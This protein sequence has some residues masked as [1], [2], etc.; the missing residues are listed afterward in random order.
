MTLRLRLPEWTTGTASVSVNGTT[1]PYTT[2]NGYAVLN[3]TWS[4]GDRVELTLPMAPS[5]VRADARVASAHG[6]VAIQRG[7]IVHCVEEVDNAAPVTHLVIARTGD[8]RTEHADGQDAIIAD[9]LVDAPAEGGL[10]RTERPGRRADRDPHGAVLRLGQPRQGHHGGLDP[11]DPL[12]SALRGAGI[13]GALPVSEADHT[14]MVRGFRSFPGIFADSA[15]S[16]APLSS[17]QVRTAERDTR[18]PLNV[19][20]RLQTVASTTRSAARGR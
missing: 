3:R 11:R 19:P 13:T 8:L 2:D 5:L 20:S 12:A 18:W 9:G 10:Y 6:K 1:L 14:A 16:E 7:P 15:E 4:P 17:D